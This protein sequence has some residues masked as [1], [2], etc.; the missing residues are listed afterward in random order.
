[1]LQRR[2]SRS[3]NFWYPVY[4][5]SWYPAVGFGR[6]KAVLAIF[7]F[8]FTLWPLSTDIWLVFRYIQ[9]TF[10]YS[11]EICQG[12]HWNLVNFFLISVNYTSDIRLISLISWY[13]ADFKQGVTPWRKYRASNPFLKTKPQNSCANHIFIGQA[14]GNSAT[15]LREKSR[16][17]YCS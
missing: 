15:A 9:E 7:P 12:F 8:F 4:K 14:S 13:V 10:F 5:R 6:N 1:M 3:D 11:A 16:L 17:N 2:E